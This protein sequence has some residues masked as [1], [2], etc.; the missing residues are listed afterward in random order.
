M[1]SLQCDGVLG[2]G[3]GGAT[4]LVLAQRKAYG[5]A[6]LLYLGLRQR[7]ATR[8]LLPR[9]GTLRATYERRQSGLL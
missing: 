8:S 1:K 4:A 6:S 3:H 9:R 5:I 7:D 2:I